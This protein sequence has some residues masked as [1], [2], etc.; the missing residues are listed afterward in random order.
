MKMELERCETR[1]RALGVAPAPLL[2]SAARLAQTRG[3]DERALLSALPHL[4][5]ALIDAAGQCSADPALVLA[6]LVQ[7]LSADLGAFTEANA[8]SRAIYRLHCDI[9]N[10]LEKDAPRESPLSDPD[11]RP[12]EV[13]PELEGPDLDAHRKLGRVLSQLSPGRRAALVGAEGLG[14]TEVELAAH[15]SRESGLVIQ[16]NSAGRLARRALAEAQG[17]VAAEA[18]ATFLRWAVG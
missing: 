11:A 16:P 2:A 18:L 12:E 9:Q 1:A 5:G 17:I 15:L 7:A 10:A 6:A 13:A 3:Q 14:L 4:A 8:R